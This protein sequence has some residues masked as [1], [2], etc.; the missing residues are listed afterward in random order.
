MLAPRQDQSTRVPSPPDPRASAVR[1]ALGLAAVPGPSVAVPEVT[2]RLAYD[3]DAR[4]LQRLAEL[5][6]QRLPVGALLVAVVAE[7]PW[8]AV[9]VHGGATIA[10][11][12]R[13][14]ADIVELLRARAAQLDARERRW[15]ALAR[16]ALALVRPRPP[17]RGNRPAFDRR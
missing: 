16:T 13:P 9:Q 6:S 7:E 5:D 1:P 12:F 14:T 15:L 17:R 11:P 4:A 2:I 10:D 3:S 8:A